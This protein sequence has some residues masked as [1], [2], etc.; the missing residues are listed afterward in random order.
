MSR[1]KSLAFKFH[2]FSAMQRGFTLVELLVGVII[3]LMVVAIALGAM[4]GTRTI[5]GS[6]GD[7][8]QIQ[9]QAAYAFRVIAK[10]IRQAGGLY[11][12]EIDT[13]GLAEVQYP[14]YILEVDNG[15]FSAD[16]SLSGLD[17]PSSGQYKLT[18]SSRE[19]IVP[20]GSQIEVRDCLGESAANGKLESRFVLDVAKHEIKCRSSNAQEQALI[21]NVADFQVRYLLQDWRSGA[22]VL[23]YSSATAIPANKWHQVVG[24]EVCLVLFGNER[25]DA[26]VPEEN[27][28][29]TGCTPLDGGAAP[30]IDIASLSGERKNRLHMSFRSVFQRRSQRRPS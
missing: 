23:K 17:N 27:R 22:P 5:A 13:F 6:T 1:N 25:M 29:Y 24:I 19:Y 21:Q 9:Q 30:R 20:P 3:G 16:D 10:Q 2:R 18:L 28:K 11:L 12:R 4:M 15:Y 14:P 8:S 7:L 26:S